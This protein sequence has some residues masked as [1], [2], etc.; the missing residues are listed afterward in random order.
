MKNAHLQSRFYADGRS[1]SLD[2]YFDVS[3]PQYIDHFR[4]AVVQFKRELEYKSALNGYK[5][6]RPVPFYFTQCPNCREIILTNREEG[7]KLDCQRC[8]QRHYTQHLNFEAAGA[9][10]FQVHELLELTVESPQTEEIVLVIQPT[11][12]KYFD[13][14]T[15]CCLRHNFEKVNLKYLFGLYTF[16]QGLQKQ[17][18]LS[19][20]NVLIYKLK[21]RFSE[22]RLRESTPSVV[23]NLI[24]D[25]QEINPG[26]RTVSSSI[27]VDNSFYSLILRGEI[28]QVIRQIN[29]ELLTNLGDVDTL[30]I[31]V[32]LLCSVN[33]LEEAVMY[34]DLLETLLTNEMQL[35]ATFDMQERFYV[36]KGTLR[37]KQ[38]LFLEAINDFKKTIEINPLNPTS[39]LG[40]MNCYLKIG[41][42]DKVEEIQA[43]ISSRGG[44]AHFLK[45]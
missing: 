4:N 38:G 44:M 32:G 23:N 19:D 15:T 9:L 25:I 36:L 5:E 31:A 33:Q 11:E 12:D 10:L 28:D 16:Q 7:F 6:L 24:L 20:K 30:M 13:R 3:N 14:I 1:Y 43:I 37:M 39:L 8:E 27:P 21:Y 35:Q 17:M 26:V 29:T 45:L 41:R 22:S 40:L 34:M 18:F 2:F 42:M